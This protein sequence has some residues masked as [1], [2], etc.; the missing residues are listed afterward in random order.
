MCKIAGKLSDDQVA[1]LAGQFSDHAFISAEQPFDAALASEGAVLHEE[2]C[3]SCHANGGKT[4]GRAP[5][6][7]GQ[8][9]KYMRATLRF[10]PTGE[11]LVPPLMERSVADLPVQDI[12]RLMNFY[13][14]QQD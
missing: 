6:I 12:D 5:R 14:S 7:A 8:W 4:A 1:A 11:H 13:A 9:T 3:E 10:V 2:S